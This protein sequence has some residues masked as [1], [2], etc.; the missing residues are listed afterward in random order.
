MSEMVNEQKPFAAEF[1]A[2]IAPAMRWWQWLLLYPGLA[3]AIL[4]AIPTYFEAVKS[5]T[6]DVTFGSS[7]DAQEQNRLWRENFECVKNVT[8][9]PIINKK[10]VEIASVVCESGD[11]LL[12]GRRPEWE[13]PQ[14][15]WVSWNEVAP[16]E[17]SAL[18][19]FVKSANASEMPY[20]V[21]AQGSS[22]SVLCQRW[23][24]AG[25]I[26]Q[27]VKTRN[28][29]FDEVIN[30]YNGS[31]VSRRSAPCNPSC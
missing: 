27:R 10:N 2:K 9:S 1:P 30:T 8:F 21:L 29:C 4:G 11:V 14:L 12:R 26:L 22:T 15:R 31:V 5:Y 17:T 3:V 13:Q 28:G 25:R 24:G 7:F 19:D 16:R 20:L 6:Y 23:V 18:F